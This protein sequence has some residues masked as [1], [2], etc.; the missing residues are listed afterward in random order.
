MSK[1][2]M[3]KP[4]T[5]PIW[6]WYEQDGC[7]FCKHR[8]GCSNCGI[9]KRSRKYEFGLKIKGEHSCNKKNKNWKRKIEM[10]E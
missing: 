1:R 10:E 6:W 5:M 3:R 2:K 4:P 8:N 7:W 9:I